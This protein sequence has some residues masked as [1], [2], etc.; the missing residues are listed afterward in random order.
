MGTGSTIGRY[1]SIVSVVPSVL[2]AVWVYLLLLTQPFGSGPSF[3][4]LSNHFSHF[5][6]AETAAVLGGALAIALFLHPLQFTIV[7]LLEGYWGPSAMMRRLRVSRT[8]T[9]L[10]RWARSESVLSGD[11]SLSEY[12]ESGGNVPAA[13]APS[14]VLTHPLRTKEAL[15]LLVAAETATTV[16]DSYPED[17]SHFLPTRLGNVLRRSELTAGASFRLPVLRFATHIGMVAEPTHTTYLNDRRTEMDLAARLCAS[18]LIATVAAV[19]CMWAHGLW[20]LT[21]LLPY[22][23]AW[24]SYRGAVSSA[25]SYGTALIAWMDLNRFAL[26]EALRLPPVEDADAERKQNELLID[27]LN[28]SPRYRTAYERSAGAG[29][30]SSRNL[31]GCEPYDS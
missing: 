15:Q 31:C 10:A 17:P 4:L 18:S 7:Q 1:F 11:D 26:Y 3:G 22:T 30:V 6:V 5:Q 14:R 23:L 21:A 25:S 19:V 12:L 13:L 28:G 29:G 24:L 2:L 27:M 9:H 16:Y 8:A 20:L